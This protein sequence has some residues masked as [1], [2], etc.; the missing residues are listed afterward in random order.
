MRGVPGSGKSTY[1]KKYFPKATV[2]SA[3]DYFSKTGAYLYD[4]SKLAEAHNECFCNFIKA[5]ERG[6]EHIVLDN[7]NILRYHYT[8]Y[9]NQAL[10]E[11]YKVVIMRMKV[12]HETAYLRQVH[13]V[14]SET[15]RRMSENFDPDPR[16]I[17]ISSL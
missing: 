14:P 3:D 2:C 16:E 6:D 13:Q 8:K 12:P 4:A 7:T 17:S 1:I 15:V 5:L 10:L 11:G 9:E